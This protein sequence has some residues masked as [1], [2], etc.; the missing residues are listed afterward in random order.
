MAISEIFV[1]L[2]QQCFGFPETTAIPKTLPV[3]LKRTVKD[4]TTKFE[5]AQSEFIKSNASEESI[6]GIYDIIYSL[7]MVE[8]K[9]FQENYI[10]ACAYE[11]VGENINASKIIEK[12]LHNNFND[13]E[14]KKI[15]LLQ[16]HIK[17]KY[18][19]DDDKIYRDLRDARLIK[20]PTKLNLNDFIISKNTVE[21]CIGLSE[22]KESIVILNK[23]VI[24]EEMLFIENKEIVFSQ[25][26][27]TNLLLEK[28]IQHL[29]W[30]AML[31]E[32]LLIFYNK[33]FNDEGKIFNV[34]KSWYDGLNVGNLSIFIDKN[35][36]FETEIILYDYIQN[37]FGFRL[38]IKNK[39]I[40][41]IEYDPI[42]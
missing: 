26:E 21:Y 39:E 17:N 38:N 14:I 18:L 36:N 10:L 41:K 6:E 33:L 11:L 2:Q 3:I 8:K 29:E 15:K 31:K 12:L 5:K 30:L 7:K 34:G 24:L 4:L 20:T 27:P 16:E 35:S 22:K 23:N 37:D 25:I 28:I 9:E 42:L 19:W 1:I 13:F 32:D 40:R